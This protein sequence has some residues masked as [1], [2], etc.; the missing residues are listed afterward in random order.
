MTVAENIGSPLKLRR[1]PDIERRVRALAERLQYGPTPDAMALDLWERHRFTAVLVTHD[2]DEAVFLADRITVLS[3][4]PSSVATV[5]ETG[6]P[7][8]QD[9][10]T[11]QELPRFLD[12]RHELLSRLLGRVTGS[13]P[14]PTP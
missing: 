4:R 11:T 10:I 14:G 1:E 9:S 7:R 3:G 5:L 2:V 6:L 13:P 12:P 8:L